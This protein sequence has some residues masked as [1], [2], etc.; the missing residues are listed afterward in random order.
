[1]TNGDTIRNGNAMQK[2]NAILIERQLK[3]Q[4][5]HQVKLRNMNFLQTKKYCYLIKKINRTS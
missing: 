5:Y 1:M 4:H 3:Y 2:Y